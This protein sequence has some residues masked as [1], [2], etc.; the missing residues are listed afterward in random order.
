M[1]NSRFQFPYLNRRRNG[2][3]DGEIPMRGVCIRR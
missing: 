1:L 2:L 3:E